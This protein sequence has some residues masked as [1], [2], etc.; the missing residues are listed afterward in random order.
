MKVLIIC[1]PEEGNATELCLYLKSEAERTGRRVVLLNA[2]DDS[3]PPVLFDAVIV[4]ATVEQRNYGPVMVNY[5]TKYNTQLNELPIFFL[6][7]VKCVDENNLQLTDETKSQTMQLL[8]KLGLRAQQV[9]TI[10]VGTKF[11][12]HQYTTFADWPKLK[13]ALQQFVIKNDLMMAG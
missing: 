2:E 11:V 6:S 1:N 5:I 3:R 4:A 8:T 13:I 7:V 12:D 10:G 9:L